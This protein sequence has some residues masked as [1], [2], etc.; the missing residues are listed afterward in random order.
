MR[1][2]FHDWEFIEDGETIKP[3]SVG[4]ACED[5]REYYAIFADREWR[6]VFRRKWLRE[7]V[8][9]Q[10]P[11]R[12]GSL[13]FYPDQSSSLYRPTDLIRNEIRDFVFAPHEPPYEFWGYFP[14]YDHVALMQLY[15]T[16]MQRPALFPMHTRCVGEYA[17]RLEVTSMLPQQ[18]IDQHNALSDA[19]W[20]KTVWEFCHRREV[21]SRHD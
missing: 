13:S 5:G 3:I 7:H 19:R 14:A 12:V 10:L 20:T 9:T 21:S 6:D 15:G 16:M 8:L 4:I 17:D 2:Y 1:R 18:P 11:G